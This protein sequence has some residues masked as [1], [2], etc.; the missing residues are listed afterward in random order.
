MKASCNC[1]TVVDKVQ[2]NVGHD[3]RGL[4]NDDQM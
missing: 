2:Q 1:S 3:S 4:H